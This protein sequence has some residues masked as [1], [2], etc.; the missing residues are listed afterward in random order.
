MQPYNTRD[1]QKALDTDGYLDLSRCGRRVKLA[2]PPLIVRQ[3][4]C[5][6][7]HSYAQEIDATGMD[8]PDGIAII[9]GD[10]AQKNTARMVVRDFSL[11]GGGLRVP[12]LNQQSYVGHIVVSGVPGV[13]VQIDGKVDPE[14]TGERMTIEHV[15]A[16]E[17]RFGWFVATDDVLSG[18][19]I[20]NCSSQHNEHEGLEVSTLTENAE[21]IDLVLRNFTCQ[22]NGKVAGSQALLRGYVNVTFDNCH[23]ESRPGEPGVGLQLNSRMFNG[24]IRRPK[25]TVRGE[26]RIN[27]CATPIESIESRQCVLESMRINRGRLRWVNGRANAANPLPI[28]AWAIPNIGMI[29][30]EPGRVPGQAAGV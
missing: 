22:G 23:I 25:I 5:F 18:A 13:A 17:S 4:Q 2:G 3:G 19:Q 21:L 14:P 8:M 24:V 26:T 20:E 30:I 1:L 12:M 16:R 7:G 29:D 6:K 10:P 11:I 27:E 9:A 28:G 15:H